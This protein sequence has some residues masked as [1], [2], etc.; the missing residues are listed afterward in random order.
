MDKERI[1]LKYCGGCNPTFDRVEYVKIIKSAAGDRIEW[2]DLNDDKWDK[3]LLI[4]GCTTACLEKN[5]DHLEDGKVLS[6]KSDDDDPEEIVKIL[7][8]EGKN[9]NQN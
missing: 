3:V 4:H 7:L 8:S 5:F 9:E 1:A 6:V 2:T